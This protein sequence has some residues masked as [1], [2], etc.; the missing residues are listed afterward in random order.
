MATPPSL[1]LLLLFAQ[2]IDAETDE[3]V[4]GSDLVIV[5][6]SDCPSGD[7]VRAELAKLRPADEWPAAVV[8]IRA[9][10]QSLAIDVGARNS[11][12]RQLVVGRDCTSRAS[13]AAL[14]IATWM[15]D[16]PAEVTRAPVL[17]AHD[18]NR[19]AAPAQRSARYEI[20]A[21]VAAAVGGGWAPGVRAE[22][23]RLPADGFLGWQA[24]VGVVGPRDLAVG[25]G[26]THWMRTNAAVGLHA[27]H[28]AERWFLAA[29][30][31]LSLALTSAWGTGYTN[32][33]SDR[34]FTW[35]PVAGVRAG[36]PWGRFRLWSEL[37][38]RWWV[39]GDS[40]RIDSPS[41]AWVDN[42]E[43]PSWEAQLSLGLGY[44]VP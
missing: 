9:T 15:D 6:E 40:V 18:V 1:L 44:V 31:G 2:S 12:Q 22:I 11:T 41:A 28:S 4:P 26:D 25:Q 39:K 30:L 19:P 37:R 42:A 23:L 36:S 7:A 10:D 24:S 16:L 29:D 3:D 17:R 21:A 20:G 38:G 27:R 33:G 13:A 5:S 43:L 8:A 32:D 14:V 35:G 34:S